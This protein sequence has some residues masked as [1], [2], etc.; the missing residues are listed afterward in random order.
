MERHGLACAFFCACEKIGAL[1]LYN[2]VY[3]QSAQSNVARFKVQIKMG[4]Q[5]DF[6]TQW[7]VSWPTE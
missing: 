1:H 3:H 5:L 4:A 6:D 7:V 2:Y